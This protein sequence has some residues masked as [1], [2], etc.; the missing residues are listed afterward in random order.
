METKLLYN[1]IRAGHIAYHERHPANIDYLLPDR[2]N[3]VCV[4]L[5]AVNIGWIPA[6]GV[7]WAIH[8]GMG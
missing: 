8:R 3:R 7:A 4:G 6:A 5:I 1:I 2:E